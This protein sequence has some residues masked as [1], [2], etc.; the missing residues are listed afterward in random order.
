MRVKRSGNGTRRE[1]KEEMTRRGKR[2]EKRKRGQD[3]GADESERKWG[4]KVSGNEKK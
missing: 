2:K 4:R 1:I 3:A